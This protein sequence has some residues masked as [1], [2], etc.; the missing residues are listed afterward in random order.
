[1][2][3][4]PDEQIAKTQAQNI[5]TQDGGH[6]LARHSPEIPDAD[7]EKRITTGITPDG[8]FSR[9]SASTRFCSYQDWLKTRQAALTEIAKQESIDLS[10]PPASGDKTQYVKVIQYD[11]PIDDGFIGKQGTEIQIPLPTNPSRQ[12]TVY[13]QTETI[14]GISRTTTTVEW[15]PNTNQWEVKQHFPNT[16]GWDQTTQSYDPSIPSHAYVNLP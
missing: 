7:L 5:E 2:S 13:S 16:K 1:M 10:Q 6:S 12:V 11:R 14:K 4:T 3:L 15:N 8:K 9:T